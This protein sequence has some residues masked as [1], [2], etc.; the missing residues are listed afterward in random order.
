[1]PTDKPYILLVTGVMAAGKSTIAQKLAE[2]ISGSVHLRGD[3]FRRMI[4]NNRA[5]ITP[6]MPQIAINQLR[7]RYRLATSAARQYYEAGFTVIYQDVVIG[8]LL[9]EV[10]DMLVDLPLYLVVLCPSAEVVEQREAQRNKA[11][12]GE[13]TARQ[14]DDELRLNTPHIGLW[15]DSSQ[16]SISATVDA[17]F[18]NINRAKI[19]AE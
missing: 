1:M 4:V 10:I 9:G 18:A 6:D 17:I 19:H 2:Q 7:L 16:L 13:W 5:E 11:A 3:I 15:L 8:A 14:L 12:Y